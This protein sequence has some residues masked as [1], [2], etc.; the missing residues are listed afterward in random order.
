MRRQA[1]DGIII[2]HLGNTNG[3]KPE[4]ENTLAYVQKALKEGW[5][6]CVDIVF[7]QGS[8]ILP[9]DGGFNVA[10]PALL[11]KQRVWCRA[12]S[13]DTVDALCNI[14]AHCFLNSE[15]FMSLTSSQFIWTLPPHELVSRSIAMLPETA[16]RSW[17]ENSEPA[18]L[19]SN[20]PLSYI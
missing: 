14:N 5:H 16:E 6:V 2:S 1:F 10:P 19:C 7:Y 11:S 9:F 18:G 13:P 12:H 3:R 17:L 8:F 15:N 20:E 4:L